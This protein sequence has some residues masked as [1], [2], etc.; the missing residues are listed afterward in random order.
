MVGSW[1]ASSTSTR[2]RH[3]A[4]SPGTFGQRFH[5]I[6][7]RIGD[8]NRGEPA[9]CPAARTVDIDDS[10]DAKRAPGD[11]ENGSP[12]IRSKSSCTSNEVAPRDRGQTSMSESITSTSRA[13]SHRWRG[14]PS[15]GDRARGWPVSNQRQ[16]DTAVAPNW[17]RA[18]AASRRYGGSTWGRSGGSPDAVSYIVWTSILTIS[19]DS[20]REKLSLG[21]LYDKDQ[22]IKAALIVICS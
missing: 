10:L 22:E 6:C 1:W 8:C 21:G 16:G 19:I 12:M 5:R 13:R 17:R 9:M 3:A 18:A 7:L 20:Q 2:R 4:A 11:S 14:R 15:A